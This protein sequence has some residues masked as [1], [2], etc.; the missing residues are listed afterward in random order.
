LR[1][2]LINGRAQ[3]FMGGANGGQMPDINELANNPNIRNM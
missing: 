2:L 3:Q 1:N